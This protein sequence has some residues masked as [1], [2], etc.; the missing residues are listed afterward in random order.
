MAAQFVAHAHEHQPATAPCLVANVIDGRGALQLVA[1]AQR[2]VTLQFAAGPHAS[3][4]RHRRHEAAAPRVAIGVDLR[5]AVQRQEVQPMPQRRQRRA[6]GEAAAGMVERCRQR[7]RGAE[8][9]GV[10][11]ASLRPIQ[12]F[13]G[14]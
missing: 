13:S 8:L 1:D 2:R 14:V 5:L 7:Q 11:G 10:V 6:F 12:S 4:Q 3:R 9:C